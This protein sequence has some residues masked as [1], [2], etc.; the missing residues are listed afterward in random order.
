MQTAS[1]QGG[2]GNIYIYF[3]DFKALQHSTV[4]G[5]SKHPIHLLFWL[6]AA[7]SVGQ[8]EFVLSLHLFSTSL[9]LIP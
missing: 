8:S 2:G 3:T 6:E 7:A 5:Q 9:I 4:R 1:E